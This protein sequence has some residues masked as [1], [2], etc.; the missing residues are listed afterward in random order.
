A[1]VRAAF[2]YHFAH[3]GKKLHFM[4]LEFGQWDEWKVKGGLDWHLLHGASPH[5]GLQ[6]LV[7]DLNRV[8]RAEPALHQRDLTPDGFQW[9]D[10]HDRDQNIVCFLRHG[11]APERDVLCAFNFS[12]VP[13]HD[14]RIGVPRHGLYTE[15]LNTDAE[16]YGGGNIGNQGGKQSDAIPSQNFADSV[17]LSLPPL[18]A[19]WLRLDES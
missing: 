6:R 7:R 12:P 17:S 9:V 2:A 16:V 15:I 19:V 13:R 11:R 4:G 8:Y 18:G 14:Y 10:F 3:P 5:A 1:N